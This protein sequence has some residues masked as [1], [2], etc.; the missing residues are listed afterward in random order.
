MSVYI[1][2]TLLTVFFPAIPDMDVESGMPTT[3][4]RQ[5]IEKTEASDRWFK[6][7]DE[8]RQLAA[9]KKLP[10]LLH[11]DATWCGACSNPRPTGLGATGSSSGPRAKE[12]RST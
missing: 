7:Y 11:F 12:S 8:A 2:T 10:L 3:E 1:V 4:M 5:Q 9:R 6:S